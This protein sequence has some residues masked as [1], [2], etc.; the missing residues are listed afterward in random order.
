MVRVPSIEPGGREERPDERHGTRDDARWG[1]G[2][3]WFVTFILF[4]IAGTLL[5][6]FAG[7]P[8]PRGLSTAF[9]VAIVATFVGAIWRRYRRDGV[10]RIVV[11]WL[12]HLVGFLLLVASFQAG[13]GKDILWTAALITVGIGWVVGARRD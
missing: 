11:A 7:V 10:T 9:V 2:G 1:P 12:I 13:A 4:A 5:A 6:L 8:F 3:P